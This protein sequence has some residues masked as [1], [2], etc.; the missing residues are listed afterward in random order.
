MA[1]LHG[2]HRGVRARL[3]VLARAL[4]GVRLM[5]QLAARRIHGH[6]VPYD[7]RAAWNVRYRQAIADGG[8]D[9]VAT[10]TRHGD[11]HKARYHYNLVE[12]AILGWALQAPFPERPAVLDVGSGAGHWIDFYRSVFDARRV[13]GI[14]LAAPAAE[15]LRSRYAAAGDV[16]IEEVDVSG[17][18]E[19]GERFDIVNAVDVLFHIVDDG[20]WRRAVENL[21][22]HL[23]P[24]GLLVVAEYVALVPHDAGL[25]RPDTERG[26]PV[27]ADVVMVTKHVR[28]LR[29]WKACGR[30]AGLTLL[31]TRRL[32]HL[33]SLA[34]PANRLLVFA[35]PR[36]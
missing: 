7:A 22:R 33:R 35:A 5:N 14:E 36:P 6:H 4:L 28:S 16:S 11:P 34:P 21:G 20:L 24:G 10:I 1:A 29:Q 25:R 26:E 32:R 12:N 30:K 2:P 3:V 9:D 15:A 31:H 17:D 13:V 8:I 23:A 27:A 19:L 18:V